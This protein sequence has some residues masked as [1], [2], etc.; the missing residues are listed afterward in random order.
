MCLEAPNDVK[1]TR[2]NG[3]RIGRETSRIHAGTGFTQARQ[4]S[5]KI[6]W[7]RRYSTVIDVTLRGAVPVLSAGSVSEIASRL[8]FQNRIRSISSLARDEVMMNLRYPQDFPTSIGSPKHSTAS[9]RLLPE[10]LSS[11]SYGAVHRSSCGVSPCSSA[12]ASILGMHTVCHLLLLAIRS[13]AIGF[14]IPTRRNEFFP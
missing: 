5:G 13:T 9:G 11:L 1:S 12:W 14:A 3:E 4:A 7:L 6:Q 8:G 10:D 2:A